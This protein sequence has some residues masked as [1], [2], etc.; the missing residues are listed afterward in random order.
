MSV[1]HNTVKALSDDPSVKVAGLAVTGG[2]ESPGL[3]F[4]GN[5]VE[6]TWATVLLGDDYGGSKFYPRFI[7]NTFRKSGDY[8]GFKW[9]RDDYSEYPSTGFFAD[10]KLQGVSFD[11]FDL[12]WSSSQPKELL[13]GE[14]CRFETRDKAGKPLPEQAVTVTDAG[15]KEVASGVSGQDGKLTL[16]VPATAVGNL[17]ENGAVIRVRRSRELGPFKA[18]CGGQAVSFSKGQPS[19]VVLTGGN[20][21]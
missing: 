20:K 8:K 10:N 16:Y 18:S 15:G 5:D 19:P 11:D 6:S 9:V 7:G 21:P 17:D 12:I 3:S 4:T 14:A 2:N 13:F 1:E